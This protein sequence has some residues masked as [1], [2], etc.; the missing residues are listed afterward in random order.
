MLAHAV[1]HDDGL[2]LVLVQLAHAGG[3]LVGGDVQRI[4]DM[5]GGELL[6]RADIQHHALVGVD[7]RG[8]FAGRQATAAAAQLVQRQEDQKDSQGADQQ[9]MVAGEFDQTSEKSL[10]VARCPDVKNVGQ[11]TQPLLTAEPRESWRPS[12]PDGKMPVLF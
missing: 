8:Q 7:Q 3:Q 9:V 12:A 1:D 2:G 6:A 11:Y 5:A 10:H 4:D